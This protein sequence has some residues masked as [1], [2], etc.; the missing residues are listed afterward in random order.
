M[1]FRLL[2]NGNL[3]LKPLLEGKNTFIFQALFLSLIDGQ[4]Q[5]NKTGSNFQ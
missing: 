1:E 5:Q 2:L 3:P 4:K